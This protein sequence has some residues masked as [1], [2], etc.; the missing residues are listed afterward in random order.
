MSPVRLL[1]C[2]GALLL[3]AAGPSGHLP[4][5][6]HLQITASR[7][8]MVD[9]YTDG[10]ALIAVGDERPV[11]HNDTLR[12]RTP[13]R[14]VADLTNGDVHVIAEDGGGLS[15]SVQFTDPAQPALAAAGRHVVLARGGAG[16][17]ATNDR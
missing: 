11:I 9:V 3:C 1:M 5:V 17:R 2:G 14:L 6:A 8:A 4:A 7:Q 10:P 16:I 13:G 15:V 12:L